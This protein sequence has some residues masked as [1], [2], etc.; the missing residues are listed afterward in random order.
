MIANE[1]QAFKVS[2]DSLRNTSLSMDEI[3]ETKML[4]EETVQFI[5]D[6]HKIERSAVYCRLLV[7]S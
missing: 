7:M 5:T 2:L 1:L 4:L 3:D 6:L